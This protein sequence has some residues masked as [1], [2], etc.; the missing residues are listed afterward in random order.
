M[1]TTR[2]T[3]TLEESVASELRDKVPSGD[4]SAFVLA[5]IRDRLRVDPVRALLDDLDRVFGPLSI[6]DQVQG[7]M[8]WNET[9]QRLSSTQA[10]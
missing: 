4:V 3:V 7:E 8:W 9:E 1:T 5:A 6:D 2:I 10:P